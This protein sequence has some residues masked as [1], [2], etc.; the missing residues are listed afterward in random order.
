[1]NILLTGNKSFI[2][3]SVESLFTN[4]KHQ[5]IGY[6]LSDGLDILNYETLYSKVL[7]CDV[8]IHLAAKE[9]DSSFDTMRT[10]LLGTWNILYAAKN[11]NI[12]KIIFLSSADSLGVFQGEGMPKYLPIDDD[13]PCHPSTPYAISKKLSE[14]MCLYFSSFTNIT[15][16]C[17][18]A[19]AVWDKS[20]YEKITTNRKNNPEYEWSPYWE[21]GAFIDIRDLSEA[22]FFSC[23][24]DISGYH[25]LLISSNDITT[26]GMTSVELVNKLHP[27][28]KW[29]GGNEYITDPYKS[30]INCTQLKKLLCWSPQYNWKDYQKNLNNKI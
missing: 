9:N 15:I 24:K 8:I 10:N 18:R 6:D 5:I 17:I 16:L 13:Y 20:T 25:C 28:V 2:G 1:M 12:R 7:R 21:Y 11:A 29:N 30:L 19:P 22:I 14:E 4:E 27:S 26:S 23:I 3:K